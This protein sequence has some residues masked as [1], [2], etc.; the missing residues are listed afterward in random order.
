MTLADRLESV[1][2][3]RGPLPV[4]EL[5]P[6]VRKQKAEVIAALNG[7]PDRFVHNRLKARASRWDVRR[8]R[9][10]GFGVGIVWPADYDAGEDALCELVRQGRRSPEEALLLVVN[11]LNGAAA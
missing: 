3:E 2:L 1:L 8:E 5:A 4:C 9:Q 7:N 11:A 6:A 10:N